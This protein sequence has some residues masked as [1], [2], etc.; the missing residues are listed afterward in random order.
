MAAPLAL[1]ISELLLN[2]LNHGF[3]NGRSGN[4]SV[5]IERTESL[6]RIEVTDDGVDMPETAQGG[7]GL[8]LTVVDLL[9]QQLNADVERHSSDAGVRTVLTLPLEAAL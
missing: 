7:D 4:V 9:S 1:V 6:L 2:A 8:G 3:P 5:T